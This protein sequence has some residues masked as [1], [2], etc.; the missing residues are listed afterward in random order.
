MILKTLGGQK[1]TFHQPIETCHIDRHQHMNKTLTANACTTIINNIGQ[2]ICIVNTSAD[3]CSTH[4][5]MIQEAN[6]NFLKN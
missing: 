2:F 1:G 5:I 3:Y 6:I 4:F